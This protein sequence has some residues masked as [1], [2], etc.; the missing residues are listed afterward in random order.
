MTP[1]LIN[2]VLDEIDKFI[3]YN[4]Y[5]DESVVI[6]LNM[7]FCSAIYICVQKELII[8]ELIKNF[9]QKL[10]KEKLFDSSQELKWSNIKKKIFRNKLNTRK[11]KKI[12]KRFIRKIKSHFYFD[13]LM[14]IDYK[15]TPQFFNTIKLFIL[16]R[17]SERKDVNS[18]LYK[19]NFDDQY[20]YTKSIFNQFNKSFLNN[21]NNNDRYII[22]INKDDLAV[23]LKHRTKSTR[24]KERLFTSLEELSILKEKRFIFYTFSDFVKDSNNLN[25]ESD[26]F[27]FYCQDINSKNSNGLF[28][29]DIFAGL[30]KEKF[31]FS[32][33]KSIYMIIEKQIPEFSIFRISEGNSFN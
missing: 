4:I 3:D 23:T 5:F 19:L 28:L 26:K 10:I 18:K 31:C 14:I 20:I 15:N 27:F 8:S 13:Y 2:T 25:S 29:A 32:D 30:L 16:Q 33:L 17:L 9:K 1:K 11:F 6:D 12:F 24:S 21:T 22:G 7:C